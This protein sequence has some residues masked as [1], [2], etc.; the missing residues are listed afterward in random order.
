MSG[1][2]NLFGTDKMRN[3]RFF[4]TSSKASDRVKF[5]VAPFSVN[6]LKIKLQ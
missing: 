5:D 4:V 1:Q 6:I 3:Y 2:C